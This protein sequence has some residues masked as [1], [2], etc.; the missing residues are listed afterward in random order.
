MTCCLLRSLPRIGT[1]SD[2]R[3]EEPSS[4]LSHVDLKH[5][6]E[7]EEGCKLNIQRLQVIA[8]IYLCLHI[9]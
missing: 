2:L 6:Q 4:L 5:L 7:D 3:G 9:K 8:F 1:S